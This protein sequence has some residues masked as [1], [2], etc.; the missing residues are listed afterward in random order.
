MCRIL[1]LLC[2]L[3]LC[4]AL[5]VDACDPPPAYYWLDST[6]AQYFITYSEEYSQRLVT[7]QDLYRTGKTFRDSSAEHK[8]SDALRYDLQQVCDTS[9]L[10]LAVLSH[11]L[12]FKMKDPGLREYSEDLFKQL[13][14]DSTCQLYKAYLGSLRMM[15]VRDEGVKG[16][17]VSGFKSFFGGKTAFGKARDGYHVI[18]EAVSRD[19]ASV[20]IR[21]LRVSAAVESADKL[22]ELLD[23][24]RIDLEWLTAYY[25]RL[26]PEER[27]LTLLTWAK[28]YYRLEG[29]LPSDSALAGMNLW[30][31]R[32]YYYSR[33]DSCLNYY[34][35][36][37]VELWKKKDSLLAAECARE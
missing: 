33:S 3:L 6:A 30:M 13:N 10:T 5:S 16:A 25:D 35:G 1:F 37:E 19:S 17:V 29:R 15:K 32:A 36:T 28:F 21:I 27:F 18:S 24:A 23:S 26:V 9:R 2:L 8:Q 20:P 22:G 7:I 4:R 12:S 31:D 11:N 14:K 34:Y